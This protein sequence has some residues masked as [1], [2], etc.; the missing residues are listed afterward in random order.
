MSAKSGRIRESPYGIE[1]V[2]HDGFFYTP[3]VLEGMMKM[4]SQFKARE[5]DVFVCSGLKTGTTWLKS[6]VASIMSQSKGNDLR[7][8]NAHD[9]IRNVE[10]IY[11]PRSMGNAEIPSPRLRGSHLPYSA[12]Q[13]QIGSLGCRIIYIARNPKDTFVSH[14]MFLPTLQGVHNGETTA[15]VSKEVFFDCFC[16]GVSVFGPF[17]DHVLGFWNAS[18]NQNNILFLTYEDMK[19][20]SLSH[21]KKIAD[22]LGQS[23]LTEEDIRYIDSQCSFQFLSTL[24][25][26][27]NGKLNM[28]NTNVSNR[29]FFRKG[30][31][32]DWKN[33]FTPDMNSRMDLAVENKFQEAGLFLKYEL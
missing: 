15:P 2:E 9:L 7:A 14:W 28:K 21:I 30:E 11:D 25:V 6:I 22:F 24:D 32:G 33:H 4:Y 16:N 18:R 3:Y 5:D 1:L 12:L 23:S 26:N 19:V 20:D 27:R 29:S 10:G 8:K 31:V 13:P 17:V